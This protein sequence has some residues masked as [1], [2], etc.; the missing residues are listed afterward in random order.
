[1][2]DTLC[3][4]ASVKEKETVVIVPQNTEHFKMNQD[5]EEAKKWLVET[6]IR[7]GMETELKTIFMEASG[8]LDEIQKVK[9]AVILTFKDF[10]EHSWFGRFSSYLCPFNTKQD[11]FRAMEV[12][13]A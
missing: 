6:A 5:Y 2:T 3:E 9:N 11:S 1:M 10:Q 13:D 8:N 7:E 4:N 12:E